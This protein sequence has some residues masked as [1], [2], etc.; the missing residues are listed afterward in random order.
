MRSLSHRKVLFPFRRER[1][2]LLKQPQRIAPP[3][4][5]IM[6]D[7]RE[8]HL[9]IPQHLTQPPPILDELATET[10]SAQ[11]E[12]VAECLPHLKGAGDPSRSPFDFNEH[13]VPRLNRQDHIDFLHQSL[14]DFPAA[15]V[16]VDASRPW[17]VYWA[18]MGL[19]LL[20]EDV[21][22]YR[23]RLVTFRYQFDGF[24][25]HHSIPTPQLS[26]S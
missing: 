26:Y 12:T 5:L 15:F 4:Q 24:R 17:M 6:V 1:S 11:K 23:D 13:G 16:A 20:G 10:S 19:Y 14:E 18:L 7:V 9:A 21:T 25:C 8:P 3:E 2:R 22:Q